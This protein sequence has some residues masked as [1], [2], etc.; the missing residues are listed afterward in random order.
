MLRLASAIVHDPFLQAVAPLIEAIGAE[1][2][3]DGEAVD[4]DVALRW[5][6][7]VVAHVRLPDMNGALARQVSLVE[8]ELG[9]PLSDLSLEEKHRAVRMLDDRGAFTVRKGVE[10]VAD[11]LGVSRFTIYNY[12][13]AA[14]AADPGSTDLEE[15]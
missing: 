12:L 14:R 8:A 6:G 4:G 11:A 1:F 13:N 3:D 10:Q 5:D 15:A 2:V 9:A 7:R